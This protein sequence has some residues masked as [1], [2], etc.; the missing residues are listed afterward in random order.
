MITLSFVCFFL[1]VLTVVYTPFAAYLKQKNQLIVIG[2]LLSIMAL[3]LQKE[4]QL[5]LIT[6]EARHGASTLQNYDSILRTSTSMLDANVSPTV[7]AS[8]MFLF[9]LPLGL[10]ASYKQFVSGTTRINLKPMDLNFGPVGPPGLVNGAMAL[11]V[12]ASLPVFQVGQSLN[13]V[14]GDEFDINALGTFGFNTAVISNN[15]KNGLTAMLDAPLPNNLTTLQRSLEI[16]ESLWISSFVNATICTLNNTSDSLERADPDYWSRVNQSFYDPPSIADYGTDLYM[17]MQSGYADFTSIIMS[18]WD[19]D[20]N[21]TFESEAIVFDTYRGQCNATWLVSRAGV[22]LEE[23][24]DCTLAPEFSKPCEGY[25]PASK[26]NWSDVTGPDL[27]QLP[28]TCNMMGLSQSFIY[29]FF[30]LLSNQPVAPVWI[31]S[32]ASAVWG[33]IAAVHGPTVWALA[34][35][36]NETLWEEAAF[37]FLKYQAPV[38][39]YKTVQT[40]QQSRWSLYFVLGIQPVLLLAFFLGRVLMYATPI[41]NGFGLISLMA[42]TSREGVDILR[43][44]AFSGQLERPVTVRISIVDDQSVETRQ[45]ASVEYE[46]NAPGRQGRIEKGKVYG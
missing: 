4:A 15:V 43:G 24:S 22:T 44:A 2:F 5:L 18:L 31:T 39:A 7:K 12:N 41:S 23:A 8:L 38:T 30:N 17:G 40:L 21:Q 37:P 20:L 28:L 1:A 34:A 46:L 32:I 26:S 3:C 25:Y 16:G 36:D 42:G 29:P 10:S 33:Q 14:L 27:L 13:S 6:L 9:A 19:T 35:P 11:T 45:G